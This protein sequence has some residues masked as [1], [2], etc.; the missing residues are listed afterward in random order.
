MKR[1]N[2][3]TSVDPGNQALGSLPFRPLPIGPAL[4]TRALFLTLLLGLLLVGGGAVARA[5]AYPPS[6][7]RVVAGTVSD[8]SVS[9][10]DTVVFSGGGFKPGSALQ[11][12]VD[13][14]QTASLT[15]DATGAFSTTVV[16]RKAGVH[17]LAV[18]GLEPGGRV[19]VVSASVTVT[20]DGAGGSGG[21]LPTT[22]AHIAAG[23]LGG[24]GLVVLG[25]T[26]VLLARARRRHQLSLA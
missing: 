25:S 5:D 12:S 4:R 10:G 23:L 7:V 18:S 15:A 2:P 9:D 26:L 17:A 8:S 20:G 14:V 24:L 1:Q 19:R 11:L 22:G 13:G 6:G 3:L 21:G 16:L